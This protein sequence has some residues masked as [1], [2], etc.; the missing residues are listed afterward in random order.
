MPAPPESRSV[1]ICA[2]PDIDT[3]DIALTALLRRYRD[4]LGYKGR[5]GVEY[6]L[7]QRKRPVA[8]RLAML[9]PMVR[10]RCDLVIWAASCQDVGRAC[11]AH[12]EKLQGRAPDSMHHGVVTLL[13]AAAKKG[14]RSVYKSDFYLRLPEGTPA[15]S[16]YTP[17][18]RSSPRTADPSASASPP[19]QVRPGT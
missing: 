18:E 17:P 13:H 3:A 8:E 9:T 14:E 10:Q 16:G 5:L 11:K 2:P 1:L 19:A 6:H 7:V 12:L 15:P 4:A